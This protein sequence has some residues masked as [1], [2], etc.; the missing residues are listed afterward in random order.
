[1]KP[2]LKRFII[3]F[4]IIIGIVVVIIIFSLWC[5]TLFTRHGQ[6]LIVPDFTGMSVEQAKK[7][8]K[9]NFLVIEVIDSL[10]LPN[11]SRGTVLRQIPHSGGSVK[12]NRRILLT[13]NS[14]VPRK[15]NAPSLVGFSL[16]QAKAEL[17]S[18]NF[19]L[20]TLYYED[21]F[22]TN[23]VLEQMYKNSTL[24]PGSPIDSHSVIDLVLGVD[25]EHNIAY[26]PNVLGLSLEN[27]KDLITDHYLNIGTVSY[28]NT[29]LTAIDSL[30]AVI[31]H[32][33][34]QASNSAIHFMGSVVNLTLSLVE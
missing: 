13:I 11:Q 26:V 7:T 25:P 4:C 18:R 33:E 3:H 16:R 21:D 2:G 19:H 34:P 32:Q 12:K 29:V 27:A 10:F 8:A 6:A 22:A 30:S 28:H 23:T 31:V 9:L 17:I 1:M 14:V 24:I 15:V 5:L 20:G